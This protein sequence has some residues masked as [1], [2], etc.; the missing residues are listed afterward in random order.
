MILG[1]APMDWF[2][3]CAFRQ[4]VKEIFQKYGEKE[5]YEL[6]LRTE[7]MNADGYIINPPG[8][9]KHLLTD[10]SQKNVIAQIFWSDEKML[11]QC[12]SDIENKYL[13]V[14]SW[15][16]LN[17]WCPAKNVMNT[18]WGSALLK[19]RKK[20]L[21]LIKKLRNTVK[22]PFSIKT[23]IGLDEPDRTEQMKFLVK[24]SK[25]V[26]MISVHGRTTKQVYSGDVDWKFI[27][28]L[29]K[30][31]QK[32]RN[33]E[34]GNR[35]KDYIPDPRSQVPE[36]KIIWN[37]GIRSYDN[38]KDVI[39]NLDWVMIGQAAIGNPRIFTPHTPSRK[40]LQETI[41]K[42]LDYMVAYEQFFQKQKANFMEVLEMPDIVKIIKKNI[43]QIVIV[44]FRKHLFQYLKWIPWSKELKQKLSQITEYK[45]LVETIQE[46]FW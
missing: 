34:Q 43:P 7:F 45:P 6:Y 46:F 44:E 5:K 20:T 38:I 14:F 29:K 2:T 1:L 18:G 25:Y 32:S 28:E 27:Y 35:N 13:K 11:V 17:M 37:W 33:Q 10:K 39:G 16:E 30:Q 21:N 36:C 40:E 15:I 19:N 31:T 9:I 12:F 23:R 41:L 42:H 22:V 24:A 8:V 26:D 3:D 4:I